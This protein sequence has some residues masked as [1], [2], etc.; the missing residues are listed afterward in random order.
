MDVLR[1]HLREVGLRAARRAPRSAP[2]ARR[3]CTGS[4]AARRSSI[5]DAAA[6]VASAVVVDPGQ[7]REHRGGDRLAELVAALVGVEP[8][9]V[10]PEPVVPAGDVAAA[11]LRGR[12]PRL[13]GTPRST[14]S[15]SGP[16][17]SAFQS[18][19]L[20]A[21]QRRMAGEAGDDRDRRPVLAVDP[22]APARCR[23]PAAR[24]AT[25]LTVMPGRAADARADA[26]RRGDGARPSRR[27]RRA[28]RAGSPRSGANAGTSRE[29]RRSSSRARCS[30]R[31]GCAPR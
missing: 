31:C 12:G 19:D 6:R 18:Q 26:G 16:G 3:A 14:A 20:A 5:V 11:R 15:R 25:R 27:R 30:A 23:R 21:H 7:G 24:G 4:C 13:P 1:P 17:N 28:D 10:V 8:R 9:L 22:R 29:A 2:R